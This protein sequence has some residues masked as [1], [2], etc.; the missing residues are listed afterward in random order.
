MRDI[1]PT[2]LM[3]A[4]RNEINDDEFD[5][6]DLKISSKNRRRSTNVSTNELFQHISKIAANMTAYKKLADELNQ[7]MVSADDFDPQEF[8]KLDN[9]AEIQYIAM[10][11][12][13]IEVKL[14]TLMGPF[15][16]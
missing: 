12:Q 8:S 16:S 14:A 15:R 9:G 10:Q 3:L 7:T 6:N 13:K 5:L 4:L 1:M 11:L 2:D